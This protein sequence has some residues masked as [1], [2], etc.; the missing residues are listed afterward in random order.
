MT[1]YNNDTKDPSNEAEIPEDG[2][3]VD[4]LPPINQSGDGTTKLN[5]E[6]G[7]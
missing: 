7:Y 5:D 2:D 4:W 3:Y 6:L 1:N